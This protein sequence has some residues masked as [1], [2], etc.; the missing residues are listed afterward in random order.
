MV[1]CIRNQLRGV[2]HGAGIG[3]FEVVPAHYLHGKEFRQSGSRLIKHTDPNGGT[4]SAAGVSPRYRLLDPVDVFGPILTALQS[5][6][7][8]DPSS[9]DCKV[10]WRSIKDS[11]GEG[12]TKVNRVPVSVAMKIDLAIP[13]PEAP[14]RGDLYKVSLVVE[15]N[16]FGTGRASARV[17]IFRVSCLNLEIFDTAELFNWSVV[18]KGGKIDLDSLWKQLPS[19]NA[20]KE[21]VA[22]FYTQIDGLD[23]LMLDRGQFCKAVHYCLHGDA[24]TMNLLKARQS[25]INNDPHWDRVT[26]KTRPFQTDDAFGVQA[27]DPL[28]GKTRSSRFIDVLRPA[29]GAPIQ[30]TGR[31]LSKTIKVIQDWTA[32]TTPMRFKNGYDHEMDSTQE[33]GGHTA[34]GL[35]QCMTQYLGK[36]A[37]GYVPNPVRVK[38]L[39]EVLDMVKS[40]AEAD[41]EGMELQGCGAHGAPFLVPTLFGV[42]CNNYGHPVAD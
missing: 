38:R 18:H 28:P 4:A 33:D 8:G 29:N 40:R 37:K 10:V 24:V 14:R 2:L 31:S 5:E 19:T 11:T 21:T 32:H 6:Y 22:A 34:F 20:I 15:D 25:W 9:I 12:P 26:G 35:R 1:D 3:T 17:V 36:T 27:M 16:Y 41:P 7:G 39:I 30:C 23:N 42:D 13:L